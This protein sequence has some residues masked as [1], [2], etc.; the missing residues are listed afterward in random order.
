VDE[1]IG[2]KKSGKLLQPGTEERGFDIGIPKWGGKKVAGGNQE[3]LPPYS[4]CRKN[5]N[6][7]GKKL[8]KTSGAGMGGKTI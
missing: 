2:E 4:I 6:K 5:T 1:P 7:Q 3:T 8:K